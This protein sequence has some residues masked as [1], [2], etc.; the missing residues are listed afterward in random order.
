MTLNLLVGKVRKLD[1]RSW[2]PG[3]F[4]PQR[5]PG[6]GRPR[7]MPPG[8]VQNPPS[9]TTHRAHLVLGRWVMPSGVSLGLGHGGVH[10]STLAPTALGHKHAGGAADRDSV[11]TSVCSCLSVISHY[12]R[13][14]WPLST[15]P[16]PGDTMRCS[17]S[18]SVS[19]SVSLS[20]CLAHTHT[21]QVYTHMCSHTCS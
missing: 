6:Q 20:V 14:A 2:L 19:F 21:P 4:H 5:P 11:A 10:L 1:V 17:A 8:P 3:S 12:R 7:P 16:A 15:G 13:A 18:P 9:F